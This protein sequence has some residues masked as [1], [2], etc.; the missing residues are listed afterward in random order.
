[1]R[2]FGLSNEHC[3]PDCISELTEQLG[4]I[5][6]MN[7]FVGQFMEVGLPYILT[8]ISIIREN[9]N[10]KKEHN[11]SEFRYAEQQAKLTPYESTYDDY[12]VILIPFELE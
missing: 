9:R 3:K 2:L 1:M 4:S 5:F 6:L 12:N 7:I 8:K 11:D 10:A